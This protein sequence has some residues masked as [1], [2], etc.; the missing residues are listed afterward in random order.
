M[1]IWL[2][3]DWFGS[4]WFSCEIRLIRVWCLTKLL[5][6][7]HSSYRT[8]APQLDRAGYKIGKVTTWVAF[9]CLVACL[10]SL[11]MENTVTIILCI[12]EHSCRTYKLIFTTRSIKVKRSVCCI[13]FIVVKWCVRLNSQVVLTLGSRWFPIYFGLVVLAIFRGAEALLTLS[14]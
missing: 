10:R 13:Q 14:I 3:F 9:E 8:C 11:R 12:L 1:H 6:F 5:S 2:I 4:R 7:L